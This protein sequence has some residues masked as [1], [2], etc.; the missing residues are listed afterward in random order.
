MIKDI[1]N[2]AEDRMKKSLEHLSKDLA[3]LRAGRANPAMVEKLSVDYY[4]VN[5]PINQLANITVP[6]A[7]LLV[8][9]PWDKSIIADI[10]KAIMKSD[11]G[12]NPNNDGNVIRIAIPQLTEER[13]KD[14]VK[15]VKKRAEEAR[16]AVRNLRR[17][18]NDMLKVSEK[19]KLFSED[20]SKKGA[21]EVQKLTDRYIKNIDSILQ[22]KEKEIIEV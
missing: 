21:D 22:A 16:V 13:R 18:A 4:G 10:E 7:R 19:D 20:E 12:I 11:L 6:E 1:I 5:T 3:A 8:I 14:L 9:Q 2:D 15:V 17:E